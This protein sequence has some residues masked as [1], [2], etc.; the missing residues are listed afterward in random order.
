MNRIRN[1]VGLPRNHSADAGAG[2][3]PSDRRRGA[4]AANDADMAD[5]TRR[6]S[7][8]DR[9]RGASIS[10][11]TG[12]GASRREGRE[13]HALTPGAT[14]SPSRRSVPSTPGHYNPPQDAPLAFGSFRR[15]D[16]GSVGLRLP[17][18]PR[19]RSRAP[20]ASTG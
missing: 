1:A 5:R 6:G 17:C 3:L 14:S 11:T 19:L 16:S 4:A 12:Q 13:E 2:G 15:S 8:G 18:L 20:P 7:A 9:A 10:E